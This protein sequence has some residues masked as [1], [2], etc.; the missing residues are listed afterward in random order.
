MGLFS[1][2]V[3]LR[4]PAQ[5]ERSREI[6]LRVDTGALFSWRPAEVLEEIGIAPAETR[7][8]RTITAALIERRIGHVIVVY[9]GRTGAANVVFGEPGD[10]AVLGATSLESLS[11]APDPVQKILVP[12]ISP[13]F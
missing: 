9:N 8:F 10:A 7:Q 6:E 13:A 2:R 3:A 11:V 12:A 1:V 5:A 4:N